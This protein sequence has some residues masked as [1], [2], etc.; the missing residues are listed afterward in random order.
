MGF[1]S[2]VKEEIA[3]IKE[4][5]AAIHSSMEVFLYPSFK[6]MILYRM[7]HKLYLKKH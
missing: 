5:D 3:I 2:E 1:I 6:V 7:A 4:R